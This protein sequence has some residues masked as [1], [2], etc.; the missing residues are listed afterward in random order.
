MSE[1]TPQD[2]DADGDDDTQEPQQQDGQPL[3]AER[4]EALI[5]KE[6]G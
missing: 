5:P 1:P 4:A 3:T 2:P 6:I